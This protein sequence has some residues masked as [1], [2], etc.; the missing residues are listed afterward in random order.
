MDKREDLPRISVDTIHE[1]QRI[2]SG[3]ANEVA[4]RIEGRLAAKDLNSIQGKDWCLRNINQVCGHA[5]PSSGH[6]SLL[7]QYVDSVFK[8]ARPNLRVNGRNFED[9]SENDEG[10]SA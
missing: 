8:I 9:M 6:G 3:Y 7:F 10:E 2:K 1:W 5:C 4:A